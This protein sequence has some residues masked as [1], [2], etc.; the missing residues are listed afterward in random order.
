MPV[1]MRAIAVFDFETDGKNPETC[2][3]VEFCCKMFN[4]RTLEEYPGGVFHS[5]MRPM[6]ETISD[7]DTVKWHAGLK[8]MK[9]EEVIELWRT[10][11][12]PEDVWTKFAAFIKPY[13]KGGQSQAPIPGGYNIVNF[14][15]K[16]VERLCQQ[17]K[18]TNREGK[19]SLFNSVYHMD[20]MQLLFLWTENSKIPE[21][22]RF[23]T[24]RKWLGL[25]DEEHHTAL[26]DVEQEA[27]V[28]IRWVLYMRRLFKPEKFAG[29]FGG[30]EDG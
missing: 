8:K 30:L 17:Y 28:L 29:A 6:D 3:P 27:A 2:Q 19:Q 15:L 25:P 4:A 12:H 21:N 7:P 24:V 16:I 26:K 9:P 20:L 13:T 10:Y 11:P 18:M 14:D 22:L 5:F 23:D 1:N